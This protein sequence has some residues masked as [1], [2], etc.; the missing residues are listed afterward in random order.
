MNINIEL[1]LPAIISA[2]VCAERV[3]PLIDKAIA[4]AIKDAIG[5]LARFLPQL[6]EALGG[7]VCD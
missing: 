6:I 3:Q 2:A 7:K 1:D 4:E 5:E